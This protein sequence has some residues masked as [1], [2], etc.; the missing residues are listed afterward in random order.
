M[1]Q[2][3]TSVGDCEIIDS[4]GCDGSQWRVASGFAAHLTCCSSWRP[5][6][7]HSFQETLF[8]ASLP[9]LTDKENLHP[10]RAQVS[11][12]AQRKRPDAHEARDLL[13]AL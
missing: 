1:E 4:A 7:S 11:I 9:L 10:W 13:L 2:K 3:E 5:L 6:A 12:L 8:P